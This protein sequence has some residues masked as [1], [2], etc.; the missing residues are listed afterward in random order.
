MLEILHYQ[1]MQNAI[2][3]AFLVSIA[4][5][6]VGTYVVVKRIVALSGGVAHAAFGGIG[7]GYFLNL[8]PLLVAIPWTVLSALGIG[9]ISRETNISEDT[10]IGMLWAVGMALGILFIHMSSG[11]APDLFSYLFGNILTV[12]SAELFF[13]AV[14]DLAIAAFAFAFYKQLEAVSFDEEFA[15][16]S[17]VPTRTLYLLLLCMVALSVVVM[18]KVMG[19]ILV[20]ALL[21]IP[22]AIS[23]GYASTLPRM[24][25]YAVA[26]SIALSIGGLWLS[27]VFDLPSGATIILLLAAAFMISSAHKKI[28][29]RAYRT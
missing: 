18:I 20:I 12:P 28:A 29:G 14:L 2:L 10:S 11:Y 25:L 13:M 9:V 27:Y 24:M 4:C 21:T 7:L 19:I 16:I 5:G 22:A 15:E 8:D 6:I 17:G 23:R 26:L 3:A 1:F